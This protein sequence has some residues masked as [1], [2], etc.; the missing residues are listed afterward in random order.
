MAIDTTKIRNA[1][2]TIKTINIE[3]RNYKAAVSHLKN[4]ELCILPGELLPMVGPSRVGKTRSVLAAFGVSKENKPDASGHMRVVVVELA[5]DS[6]NGEFSTKGFTVACLKAIHHPIYGTA[7]PSDPWGEKLNGL[8]HRTSE[9][10]LHQAFQLALR[11]R[12]TEVLVFDESHHVKY[13]PGGVPAA[14]RIMESW[15]CMAN[16]TQIKLV[17]TGSYSL[18]ELMALA[19]HL[20]GRQLPLEFPRY[21]ASAQD[22]LAWQEVLA[23]FDRLLPLADSSHSI[24]DWSRLLFDGSYGCVGQLSRWLRSCLS[25]MLAEGIPYVTKEHLEC[26]RLSALN[27]SAIAREIINGERSLARFDNATAAGTTAVPAGELATANNREK[28]AS[29]SNMPFKPFRRHSRRSPAKGRI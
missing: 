20:L 2:E 11:K 24:R 13:A 8:L 10:I 1:I 21:R 26:T 27:E 15:K 23:C 14:T 19:P 25:Y 29:A 6:T 4:A 7:A 3:H 22:I 9:T 28:S 16:E 12:T 18:L 17:V 5:N